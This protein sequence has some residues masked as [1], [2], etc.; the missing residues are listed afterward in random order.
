MP[1]KF[2]AAMTFPV[3]NKRLFQPDYPSVEPQGAKGIHFNGYKICLYV[4]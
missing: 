4:E 3:V 1:Q 2:Q